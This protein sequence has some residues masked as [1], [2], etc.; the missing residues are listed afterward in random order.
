MT[1]SQLTP[2]AQIWLVSLLLFISVFAFITLF[3]QVWWPP[4]TTK[5]SVQQIHVAPTTYSPSPVATP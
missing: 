1:H 3:L 2:L 5:N 4:L